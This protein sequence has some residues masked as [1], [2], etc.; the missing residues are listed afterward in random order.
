MI[1][2]TSRTRTTTGE[3]P[4]PALAGC[5]PRRAQGARRI[6]EPSTRLHGEVWTVGV[7]GQDIVVG[8]DDT[9]AAAAAVHW[10]AEL[11]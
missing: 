6:L 10:A 5:G 8:Y 9:S 3:H 11:A 1:P 7:S 2:R 4:G